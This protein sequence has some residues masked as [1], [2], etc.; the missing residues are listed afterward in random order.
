M[1]LRC[2]RS[3]DNLRLSRCPGI[4]PDY[5]HCS[6]MITRGDAPHYGH[7]PYS[8]LFPLTLSLASSALSNSSLFFLITS[9]LTDTS[10]PPRCICSH[11]RQSLHTTIHCVHRRFTY[12]SPDPVTFGLKTRQSQG[13]ISNSP[14]VV[15]IERQSHIRQALQL[16]MRD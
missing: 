12:R 4:L 9:D 11:R 5:R 7:S 15:C 16:Y 3:F 10:V 1:E 14:S 6:V 13:G 8:S 2:K